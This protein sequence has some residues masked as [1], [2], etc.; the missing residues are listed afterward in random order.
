VREADVA[1]A[2]DLDVDISDL[3]GTD[4][5]TIT[6]E[7]SGTNLKFFSATTPGGTNGASIYEA[8]VGTVTLLLSDFGTATGIDETRPFL[9]VRNSGVVPGHY[10]LTF[11]NMV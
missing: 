6:I 2:A 3:E 5:S 4:E 8:S 9:T 11:T 1:F 10:K 7:V